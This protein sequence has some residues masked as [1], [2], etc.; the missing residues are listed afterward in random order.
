M[1]KL[2]KLDPEQNLTHQWPFWLTNGVLFIASFSLSM[3]ILYKGDYSAD[4]SPVGF[5]TFLYDFGFPISIAALIIP[6]SAL[7][8]TMHISSQLSTQINLLMQQNNFANYYKHYEMFE[9]HFKMLQTEEELL[10][11]KNCFRI[12]KRL[13][14]E[15][16][17]GNYNVN[18]NLLVELNALSEEYYLFLKSLESV[19]KTVNYFDFLSFSGGVLI[20]LN[21]IWE[22]PWYI[23]LQNF[24]KTLTEEVRADIGEV[25]PIIREGV[26]VRFMDAEPE[27]VITDRILNYFNLIKKIIEFD[28]NFRE[29]EI[30][31]DYYSLMCTSL[32]ATVRGVDH[33]IANR[34]I[35]LMFAHD[36]ERL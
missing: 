10:N 34:K 13:F 6:A 5:R 11:G 24:S 15:S 19:D 30:V 9:K 36:R 2:F 35:Q 29:E 1:S 27:E 33:R 20:R 22:E 21:R 32:A 8:A 26:K 16:N 23:P 14:Q 12:Y 28:I 17:N 25:E 4:W 7:I 3:V 18:K 31:K